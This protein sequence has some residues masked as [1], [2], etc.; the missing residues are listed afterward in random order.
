V[1]PDPTSVLVRVDASRA[2]GTGH[3]M[4]CATLARSL[5]ARGATVRFLLGGES[6]ATIAGPVIDD[7]FEVTLLPESADPFRWADDLRLTL[8]VLEEVG[9]VDL[10][11][12]DHYGL[13]RRWESPVASTGAAV[14]VIDDLADRPHD[15]GLLLDQNLYE[16]LSERYSELVPEDCRLLLGPRWALLRDEFITAAGS[17]RE[18]D[19]QVATVLVS[20]GGS[21]PTGE[22]SKALR[23]LTAID[24]LCR[25]DVV[26]GQAAALTDVLRGF[27]ERDERVNLHRDVTDMAALM[28]TAD[29]ALGAGG[30]TTWE[31]ALLG[32][33]SVV[34]TVAPNQA[35]SVRTLAARGA[36]LG[37]GPAE[38]VTS[39]SIEETVCG[40]LDDPAR[41]RDLGNRARDLMG[42]ACGSS[43]VAEAMLEVARARS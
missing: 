31:R 27:A 3:L 11:I 34:T 19:G 28:V 25:I 32:V 14:A 21:D 42:D 26:I 37:L 12:V 24:S 4:R 7:G 9:D 10:A 35:E 22:T 33:P 13:D 41:V 8:E 39:G 43:A 15:C 38:S 6:A 29:L 20:Y 17:P 2:L 1:T 16:H 40:L 23:A 36:V 5:R 18:R 30:A